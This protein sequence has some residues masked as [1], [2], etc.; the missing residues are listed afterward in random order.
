MLLPFDRGDL[1]NRVH[2][3]GEVLRES[4]P[5]PGRGCGRVPAA[6]AAELEPYQ[7]GGVPA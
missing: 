4:T 5:A 7:A 1:V 6:L 2:A 3:S